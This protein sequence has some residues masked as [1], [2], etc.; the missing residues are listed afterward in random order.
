VV[1]K[2]GTRAECVEFHAHLFNG[3]I[4]LT[5]DA[6]PEEQQGY[7]QYVATNLTFLRGKNLACWCSLDGPCHVDKL[8]E[9]ASR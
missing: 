9:V 8:L 1:G 3:L 4:C 6:T 2:D 7:R 5:C